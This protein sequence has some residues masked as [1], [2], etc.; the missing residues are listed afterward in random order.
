MSETAMDIWADD[1]GPIAKDQSKNVDLDSDSLKLWKALHGAFDFFNDNLF[2][3]ILDRNKV[4]LNC[5]RMSRA[6]GFH[7]NPTIGWAPVEREGF[8][9]AEE[10]SD[11]KNNKAEISLN[12]S[13]M[14]GRSIN[15]IYST[16]VHE[17]CHFQQYF[18]GDKYPKRG[19][20]NKEWATM[21]ERVGLA[22]YNVSDPSKRTGMR[23]SH[24]IVPGGVFELAMEKMPEE[25]KFPFRGLPMG[26]SKGKTGYHKWICS[27]CKQVARAKGNAKLACIPC[28][29]AGGE[30]VSM[31][32]PELEE[33]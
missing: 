1:G 32:C 11:K 16:F 14:M 6:L 26:G 5:S 15:E 22:P 13:Y 23:C 21:M 3:G 25:F 2:G 7:A 29:E 30:M 17:M 33:D 10:D 8:Y 27:T 19:Y 9:P 12:P 4:I 31:I 18:Y 24:K 20:H 28:S